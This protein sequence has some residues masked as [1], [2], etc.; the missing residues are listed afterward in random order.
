MKS[1]TYTLSN[2]TDLG[3][4]TNAL[5]RVLNSNVK[6]KGEK[7]GV[8]IQNEE[9]IRNLKQNALLHVIFQ[10]I[11][12]A[13]E[14]M[15]TG[16]RQ[17]PKKIK[18]ILKHEFLGYEVFETRKAEIEVMRSTRKLTKREC[19]AFTKEILD[20]CKKYKIEIV[21]MTDEYNYLMGGV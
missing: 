21:V 12:D 14:S 1:E 18:A 9:S 16:V 3:T 7:I 4:I 2:T 20:W 19:S 13:T 15:G 10:R 5:Q 6:D 8:L 17:S 11:S